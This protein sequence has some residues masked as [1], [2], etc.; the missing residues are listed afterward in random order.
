MLVLNPFRLNGKE[1]PRDQWSG[2]QKNVLAVPAKA[3]GKGLDANCFV[4]K[5]RPGRPNS[6]WATPPRDPVEAD[7]HATMVCESLLADRNHVPEAWPVLTAPVK[8]VRLWQKLQDNF[9]RQPY[10]PFGT[11][12]GWPSTFYLVADYNPEVPFRGSYSPVSGDRPGRTIIYAVT[13]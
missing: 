2:P 13:K 3:K 1:D 6:E 5:V 9:A 7:R 10:H 11:D 4:P 12:R 8:A